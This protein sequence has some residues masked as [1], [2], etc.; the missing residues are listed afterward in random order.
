MFV[1]E[2]VRQ[3]EEYE[4]FQEDTIGMLA[5]FLA[6]SLQ[7]LARKCKKLAYLQGKR[8]TNLLH[9]LWALDMDRVDLLALSEYMRDRQEDKRRF[10]RTIFMS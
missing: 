2:Y 10:Q 7:R 3:F 1:S 8:R 9:V 4:R 5:T 6:M